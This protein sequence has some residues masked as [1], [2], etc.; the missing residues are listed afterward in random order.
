MT[1]SGPTSRSE[2]L[3][4][5]AGFLPR[6]ARVQ[7]PPDRLQFRN[8]L[9][10]RTRDSESRNPVT[11]A[12]GFAGDARDLASLG[13]NPG[14]ET[15]TGHVRPTGRVCPLVFDNRCRKGGGGRTK[16]SPFSEVGM[17]QAGAVVTRCSLHVRLVPSEPNA[18]V[19]LVGAHSFRKRDQ[20]GSTPLAS[21]SPGRRRKRSCL[22][23]GA[24]TDG[25][26]LVLQTSMTGS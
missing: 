18:G 15:K 19:A 5:H 11:C 12:P 26:W 6:A 17:W 16:P 8:R 24:C 13:A 1:P 9:T 21:S 23:Y 22:P 10:G 3:K 14:S 4:R 25:R 7:F 20:G 2:V